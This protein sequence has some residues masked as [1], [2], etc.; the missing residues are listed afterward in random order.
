MTRSIV[1]A[2]AR[3]LGLTVAAAMLVYLVVEHSTALATDLLAPPEGWRVYK[4]SEL[5]DPDRECVGQ[6]WVN[7]FARV[8]NGVLKLS[9]GPVVMPGPLDVPY[10]GGRLVGQDLGEWGGR[11]EWIPSEG[12]MR[13]PILAENTQSLVRSPTG[14]FLLT[15]SDGWGATVDSWGTVGEGKIW[16]LSDENVSPPNAVLVANLEGAP[17]ASF[18]SP[19]GS[20][21]IVTLAQ[22]IRL[23]PSGSTETILRVDFRG[24]FPNSIVEMADGVIYIGM[25]HFL[26]R[27]VPTGGGYQLAWLLPADC[28]LFKPADHDCVCSAPA[29]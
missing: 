2:F 27:L 7:R 16:R 20:I 14:N 18:L 28:P 6:A 24:L 23:S 3:H 29:P 8:S 10:A 11:L 19:D 22:V 25:R 26:G 1:A 4:I 15:G 13:S 12:S 17:R 21:V 5:S 9:S